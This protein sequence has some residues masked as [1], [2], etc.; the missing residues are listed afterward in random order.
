MWRYGR[1]LVWN[2]HACKR[3][4]GTLSIPQSKPSLKMPANPVT[5]QDHVKWPAVK[6]FGGTQAQRQNVATRLLQIPEWHTKLKHEAITICLLTDDLFHESVA[7]EA[8]T[9]NEQSIDLPSSTSSSSSPSSPLAEAFLKGDLIG[10]ILTIFH[11]DAQEKRHLIKVHG[12]DVVRSWAK[13]TLRQHLASMGSVGATGLILEPILMD[14]ASQNSDET[15]EDDALLAQALVKKISL[16][17]SV[18][19]GTLIPERH[20]GKLVL[21]VF[22]RRET[23]PSEGLHRVERLLLDYCRKNLIT[24]QTYYLALDR[25]YSSD[26]EVRDREAL[27]FKRV[28]AALPRG[29]LVLG[30]EAALDVLMEWTLQ[31]R[32]REGL[33]SPQPNAHACPTS[34]GSPTHP[35][36]LDVDMS[37]F[38]LALV[39]FFYGP[40]SD[41]LAGSHRLENLGPQD[42]ILVTDDGHH[43]Y[44]DGHHGGSRDCYGLKSAG[45]GK[46]GTFGAAGV[47]AVPSIQAVV[48]G[49]NVAK[50][51][52][53]RLEEKFGSDQ[54]PKVVCGDLQKQELSAYSLVV[55]HSGNHP[56]EPSTYRRRL[57]ICKN[58][59]VA[60]STPSQL[61]TW[62]HR[63]ASLA[64]VLKV[65]PRSFKARVLGEGENPE[66]VHGD[67][68]R[69]CDK[70]EENLA[71]GKQKDHI[72]TLKSQKRMIGTATHDESPWGHGFAK[73]GDNACSECG[74]WSCGECT[75]VGG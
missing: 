22:P 50:M 65:W 17:T 44:D 12:T 25:A 46:G 33:L 68:L 13:D 29:S 39:N 36:V 30:E 6:I 48:R 16:E 53:K 75:K 49:Q 67:R 24:L 58:A 54:S 63:P 41:V 10:T 55:I 47:G 32:C 23:R 5:S 73:L 69:E 34:D 26:V 51:L 31:A 43:P 28:V 66:D 2:S 59:G 38:Y 3:F 4:R 27:R 9:I 56:I 40:P 61:K 64:A 15:Y 60:V 7:T 14:L 45:I 72:N 11:V 52:R 62:L 21:L 8:S 71:G 42:T 57:D 37:T 18:L 20:A 1:T 35:P 74:S 19:L 70:Q